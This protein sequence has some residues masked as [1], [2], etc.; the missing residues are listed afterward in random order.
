MRKRFKKP[1]QKL[2]QKNK[3]QHNNGKNKA[4]KLMINNYKMPLTEQPQKLLGKINFKE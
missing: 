3:S 4:K 1:K 2:K